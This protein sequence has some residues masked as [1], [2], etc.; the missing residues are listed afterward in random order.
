VDGSNARELPL[1]ADRAQGLRAGDL[2]VADV[3]TCNSPVL[4]LRNKRSLSS[5][6]LLKLPTPENCHSVPTVPRDSEPVISLLLMLLTS[7]SPAKSLRAIAE[8]LN[9]RGVPQRA[10]DAGKG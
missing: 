8:A 4:E 1:Q 5:G 7:N 9:A 10:A 3:V 6:L 2:V